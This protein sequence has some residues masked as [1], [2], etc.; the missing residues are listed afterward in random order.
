[1]INQIRCLGVL[2]TIEARQK[3]YPIRYPY[4]EFYYNYWQCG[5]PES[6]RAAAAKY[7]DT[8]LDQWRSHC[9]V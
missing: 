8:D 4:K 1:M 6:Y 9:E 7:S 2:A 5:G 3:A